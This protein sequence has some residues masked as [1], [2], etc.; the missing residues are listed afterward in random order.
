MKKTALLA[1]VLHLL[2][3]AGSHAAITRDSVNIPLF[4]KVY[5]FTQTPTPKNIVVMISGD[6]GWRS[7][8]SGYSETFASM[9]SLVVGVDAYEYYKI[10]KTRTEECYNFSADFIQL[11]TFIEKKYDF[12]DYVPPV[13]MGFA[14]GATL[15]YAILI[16]SH[17]GNFIAG[18]SVGFCPE[19]DIQKT[20]C[21]INGISAKTAGQGKKYLL[22]PYEGLDIPWIVLNGKLDKVCSYAS[23]QEFTSKINSAELVELTK[24]GHSYSRSADFMPQWKDSYS[25]IIS[26][27]ESEKPAQVS[28]DEVK[29]LPLIITNSKFSDKKAPLALL[30]S[31]DGGWYGFEQQIA[32]NLALRGVPTIG[33]DSKKYFWHRRTPEQT[34]AD[35]AKALT[36]Y[37]NQWGRNKYVIVGYSLGAELVPFIINR[38]P[39]DV[40][41]KVQSSALLSPATSTDFEIHISNMLGMGNR[42]N[43]YNTTDEIIKMKNVRTLLIFGEG[44]KTELPELLAGTKAVIRKIPGDHHYKFNLPL[45]MQTMTEN[46]IF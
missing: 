41:S 19:I 3:F 17:Q 24:V 45:I 7:S 30:I 35:I 1:V 38:L 34:A 22:Q 8:V 29:D 27:Y 36:F 39:K 6:S 23:I 10:L 25:K 26:K 12:P 46:N 5:T 28:P 33:L 43:T 18:M 42:Q 37:G 4:G 21:D 11:I 31:G 16:Q 40:K 32:D 15:V 9:N 44:E 20:P 2:I 13:L 14:G